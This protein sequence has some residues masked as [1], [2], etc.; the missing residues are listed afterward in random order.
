M[1]TAEIKAFEVEEN[2]TFETCVTGESV[3]ER[4]EPDTKAPVKRS[5]SL[6]HGFIKFS[7]VDER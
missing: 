5:P 7:F 6:H 3:T 1:S 2:R 4:A